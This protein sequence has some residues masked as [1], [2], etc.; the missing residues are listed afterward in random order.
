M[1]GDVFIPIVMF[2]VV[3][4]SIYFWLSFRAKT[5]IAEQETLRKAIDQGQ[6]LSEDMVQALTS[7][8]PLPNRDLRRGLVL[9]ALSIA[10]MGFGLVLNDEDATFV[11]FGISLFPLLLSF[12]YLAMHKFGL[13]KD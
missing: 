6:T 5:R 3:F 4:S 12:A 8:R 11:L 1:D 13:A 9:L 7:F 2:V 10:T